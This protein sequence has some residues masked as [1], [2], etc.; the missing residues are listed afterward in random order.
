MLNKVARNTIQVESS[1]MVNLSS[2]SKM[3][4]FTQVMFYILVSLMKVN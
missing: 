4:K 1:L 3:S 2:M